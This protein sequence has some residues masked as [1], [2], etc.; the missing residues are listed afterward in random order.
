[1]L[2]GDSG[3]TATHELIQNLPTISFGKK[4]PSLNLSGLFFWDYGRVII[5]H[6][7]IR[8]PKS[9][10]LASV[11]IGL[12]LSVANHFSA[13]ADLARQLEQDERQGV[14]HH[15]LHVKLGLTY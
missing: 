6:P 4:L 12:R 2:S 8:E 15:R 7:L 13:S 14:R 3:Y 1:M 11:G 5:K 9:A 10:Y